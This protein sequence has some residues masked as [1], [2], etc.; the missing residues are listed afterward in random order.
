M[1]SSGPKKPT[2][3]EWLELL[4]MFIAA[5]AAIIQALK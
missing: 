5:I 3:F 4:A 1:R 2:A